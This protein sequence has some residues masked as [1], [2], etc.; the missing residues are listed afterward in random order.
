[1]QKADDRQAR[2]ELTNL[3]ILG[4]PV[5]VFL[6]MLVELSA[7]RPAV[8][9]L[10]LYALVVCAYSAWVVGWEYTRFRS[11]HKLKS[12]ALDMLLLAMAF[13]SLLKSQR[14]AEDLELYLR[15][16]AAFAFFSCVWQVFTMTR[17]YG[18]Y[19]E[20]AHS[21]LT[22]RSWLRLV[23][24]PVGPTRHSLTHWDEYRY[25]LLVE[26]SG[27]LF[28]VALLAFYPSLLRVLPELSTNCLVVGV[29]SIEGTLNVVRYR[30]VLRNASS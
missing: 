11:L 19:F 15:W 7:K 28:L 26:G 27:V 18:P 14:N 2:I 23:T 10:E 9:L 12:P 1:M 30:I 21:P 16:F 17:G 4:I 3:L 22:L 29:G 24:L 5:G 8:L 6:A 13:V 25:W 20:P